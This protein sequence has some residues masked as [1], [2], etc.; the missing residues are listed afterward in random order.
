MS[1]NEEIKKLDELRLK[2]GAEARAFYK[3]VDLPG[4]RTKGIGEARAAIKAMQAERA[5]PNS[6]KPE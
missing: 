3:T 1:L 4:S 5:K 6:K 2:E